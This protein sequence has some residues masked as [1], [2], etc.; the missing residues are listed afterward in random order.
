M[1][2]NYINRLYSQQY[3]KKRL[4][5]F[6]YVFYASYETIDVSDVSNIHKYLIKKHDFV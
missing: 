4:K 3:E 1:S 2:E 5:R 6:V